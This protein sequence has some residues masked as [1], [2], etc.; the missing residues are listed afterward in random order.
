[1]DDLELV[2]PDE[3]IVFL[4]T[5]K[6]DDKVIKEDETLEVNKIKT[7]IVIIWVV[8]RD[9]GTLLF[10]VD[11][12]SAIEARMVDTTRILDLELEDTKEE[13]NGI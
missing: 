2:K 7:K 13:V 1:M 4:K 10:K 11:I 12:H 9:E 5:V 3:K 6:A 8:D